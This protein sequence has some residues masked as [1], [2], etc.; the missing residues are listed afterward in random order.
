[1]KSNS[2]TKRPACTSEKNKKADDQ[3][4]IKDEGNGKK[5]N[6]ITVS[7]LQM[8]MKSWSDSRSPIPT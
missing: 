2:K 6:L 4:E 1:M 8:A 5:V 7:T 3:E